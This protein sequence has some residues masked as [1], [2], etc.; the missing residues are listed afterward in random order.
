MTASSNA[1]GISSIPSSA[2][3]L[4]PRRAITAEP[5]SRYLVRQAVD[6]GGA[7]SSPET[8]SLSPSRTCASDAVPLRTR[9]ASSHGAVR[10]P[11]PSECGATTSSSEVGAIDHTPRSSMRVR[12]ASAIATIA[13]T[14][15]TARATLRRVRDSSASDFGV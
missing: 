14:A 13:A 15:S 2:G 5:R 6:A 7:S 10:K 1:G 12:V 3:S 4:A 9:C 8:K 11:P